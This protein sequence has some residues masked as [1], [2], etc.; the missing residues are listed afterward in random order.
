MS[1]V[2]NWIAIVAVLAVTL[3]GAVAINRTASDRDAVT[4]SAMVTMC[5]QLNAGRM[6]ISVEFDRMEVLSQAVSRALATAS[7]SEEFTPTEQIEYAKL[8]AMLDSSPAPNP[9]PYLHCDKLFV[10]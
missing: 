5:E 6:E 7:R 3:L 4:R 9:L 2:H 10:Q 1:H 8:Q